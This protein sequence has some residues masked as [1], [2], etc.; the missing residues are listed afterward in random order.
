MPKPGSPMPGPAGLAEWL[1]LLGSI[2][3]I[4]AS[5]GEAEET[6]R[7]DADAVMAQPLGTGEDRG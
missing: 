4:L 2:C 1:P 6:E 7:G 5:F 3:Q